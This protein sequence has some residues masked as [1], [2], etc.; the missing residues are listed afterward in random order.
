MNPKCIDQEKFDVSIVVPVFNRY[1]RLQIVV[2]SL[3]SQDFTGS[4]EIVIVDDGSTDGTGNNLQNVD[5]KIRVIRQENQGAAAARHTGVA[6][7][8]GDI[9]V[10]NDSDDIAYPNKL[11]ILVD[12]LEANPHCVAAIAVVKNPSKV[13]WSP[14]SWVKEM[15]GSYLVNNDPLDHFFNNYYPI[16]AAMNIAVKRDIAYFAS[17]ESEY[18][19]A[20]ND[21][22]FQFKVATKGPI[23]C[24][25]KITNEY[26]VGQ[27]ITTVQGIHTQAAYALISL[28][29]NYRALGKPPKFA[30]S[31]Q[32][33]IENGSS[34]VLKPLLKSR[35]FELL[36][37]VCKNMLR[38]SRLKQIPRTVWWAI[39]S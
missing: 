13:D 30:L 3:M 21:F 25:S 4:Y 5:G 15:D 27:G 9:V 24:V 8:K 34:H 39:S 35:K 12:A 31:V 37:A 11:Q 1:E 23:V 18:Y 17:K 38:Y 20:A 33:R 10:F 22:H 2:D 32:K 6:H 14:P 16:A 7:A 36:F 29:D 26:F 19:R 28:A